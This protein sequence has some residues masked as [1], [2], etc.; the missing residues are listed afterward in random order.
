MLVPF[1]QISFWVTKL[2]INAAIAPVSTGVMFHYRAPLGHTMIVPK[3]AV[4]TQ[5]LQ[6]Y[7]IRLDKILS[8][9]Q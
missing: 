8:N 1:L 3:K 6:F 5:R 4:E 2:P 7:K 9:I